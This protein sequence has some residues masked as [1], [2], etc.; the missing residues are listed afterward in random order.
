M[1]RKKPL[2]SDQFIGGCTLTLHFIHIV[3]RDSTPGSSDAC[4]ESGHNVEQ[5]YHS[6]VQCLSLIEVTEFHI[7]MR[8]IISLFLF[9]VS[10]E[11]NCLASVLS[12]LIHYC[13]TLTDG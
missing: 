5:P 10:V 11:C 3:E 7:V 6:H 13:V 2:E 1:T 8:T 4:E 9:F 12:V